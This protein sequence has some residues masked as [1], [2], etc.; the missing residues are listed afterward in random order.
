MNFTVHIQNISKYIRAQFPDTGSQAR[1][2]L[3]SV[4]LHPIDVDTPGP[5]DPAG[6]ADG[7]GIA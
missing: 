3:Y 5:V 6:Q 1:N 2:F 7:T 4:I